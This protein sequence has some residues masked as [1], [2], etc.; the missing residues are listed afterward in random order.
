MR[1]LHLFALSDK[2]GKSLAQS[3]KN[4]IDKV[5]PHGIT[6]VKSGK[7]LIIIRFATALVKNVKGLEPSS[8]LL[9]IHRQLSGTGQKF[10]FF[11]FKKCKQLFLVP[12]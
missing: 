3:F 12:E 7:E 10:S 8:S 1:P 5:G 9:H 4:G 11:L 6:G 2:L